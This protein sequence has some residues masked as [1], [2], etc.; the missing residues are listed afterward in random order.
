MVHNLSYLIW[1]TI[2]LNQ[3]GKSFMFYF[4]MKIQKS[5]RQ[6]CSHT[7]HIQ[8]IHRSLVAPYQVF[9]T[10]SHSS[11]SH[12]PVKQ[13][14]FAFSLHASFLHGILEVFGLSLLNHILSSFSYS[15]FTPSS[16]NTSYKKF[17]NITLSIP[18]KDNTQAADRFQICYSIFTILVK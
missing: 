17:L 4:F 9:T 1:K 7:H 13:T 8:A 6:V 11:S 18:L 2:V 12:K 10:V 16:L 3:C 14:K 5:S 15:R